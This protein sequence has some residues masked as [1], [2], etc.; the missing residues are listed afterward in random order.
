MTEGR[1]NK[2]SKDAFIAQCKRINTT[3]KMAIKWNESLLKVSKA[4]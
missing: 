2:R 3:F 1:K 4:S